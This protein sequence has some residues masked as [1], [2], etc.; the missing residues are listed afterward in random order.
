MSEPAIVGR[1]LGVL[2]GSP[3]SMGLATECGQ[4]GKLLMM[5][6]GHADLLC[7]FSCLGQKREDR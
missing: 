6:G 5:V 2:R 3:K 4:Q 7:C 1:G